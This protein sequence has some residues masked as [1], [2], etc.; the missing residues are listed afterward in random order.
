MPQFHERLEVFLERLGVDALAFVDHQQGKRPLTPLRIGDTDHRH[1]ADRRV[2][3]DQVF[4][5]Q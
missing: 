5:L 1:F 4:K 2:A 3:A